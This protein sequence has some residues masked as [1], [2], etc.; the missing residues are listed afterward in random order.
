MTKIEAY[1]ACKGIVPKG[2]RC[3]NDGIRIWPK[4]GGGFYHDPT[5][6]RLSAEAAR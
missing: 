1:R 4:R 5:E 6:V 3:A 2:G